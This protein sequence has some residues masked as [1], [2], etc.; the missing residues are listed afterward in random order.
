MDIKKIKEKYE[1][2]KEMHERI[3]VY[4]FISDVFAKGKSEILICH[5]DEG[6][7]TFYLEVKE[8]KPIERK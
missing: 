3:G 2:R 1:L 8:I 4:D 6:T 5:T 7:K